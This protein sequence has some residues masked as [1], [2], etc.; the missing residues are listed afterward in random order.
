MAA[1]ACCCTVTVALLL[2]LASLAPTAGQAA[3]YTAGLLY[4]QILEPQWLTAEAAVHLAVHH[5]NERNFSVV[6]QEVGAALTPGFRLELVYYPGL[7]S[8]APN[9]GQRAAE[10]VYAA[11][12]NDGAIA[13][14]GPYTSREAL[15]AASVA[16]VS[17]NLI[18]NLPDVCLDV[19]LTSCYLRQSW[20]WLAEARV[21]RLGG[22]TCFMCVLRSVGPASSS[23]VVYIIK[24]RAQ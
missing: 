7:S 9:L 18:R 20:V 2:L 16:S 14:I 12:S 8:D 23:N 10:D 1:R 21:G 6:G 22:L 15:Q 5:I 24:H 19:W 4:P 3:S 11:H 17:P 13:V